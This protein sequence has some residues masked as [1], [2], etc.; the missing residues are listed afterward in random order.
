MKR[1]SIVGLCLVAMFAMSA[2]AAGTASAAPELKT[3]VKAEKV[4]KVYP[5]GEFSDKYCGKAEAGGKY[6]IG[7]F[8]EAKKTGLKIKG[9]A[10]ANFSWIPTGYPGTPTGATECTGEKGEGTYTATGATFKVEYKGCHNGAK[11]CAS[12]GAKAGVVVD[13]ELKGTLVDLPSGKVGID[14][15]N[16]AS[17][18]GTLAA[19]DCEGLVVDAVGGVIGEVQGGRTEASKSLFFNF[20]TGP[21]GVQQQWTYPLTTLSEEEGDKEAYRYVNEEFEGKTPAAKTPTIL[22]S[23]ISGEAEAT[24]PSTQG[25]KSEAKGEAFKIVG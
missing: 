15:A 14:I 2:V 1:I 22:F 6:K 5:T 7:S 17:P 3:C 18:G 21:K 12:A 9:G 10:G 11:K 13:E 19:Y 20:T 24:L 23:I 16:A 4:G 8:S 25:S